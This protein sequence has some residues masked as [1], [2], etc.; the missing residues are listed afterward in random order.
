MI[1]SIAYSSHHSYTFLD[2]LPHGF[3]GSQL[4]SA[5]FTPILYS[6]VCIFTIC[7]SLAHILFI[8][9]N[10]RGTHGHMQPCSHWKSKSLSINQMWNYS[11][12][13]QVQ[14][15]PWEQVERGGVKVKIYVIFSCWLA[16]FIPVNCSFSHWVLVTLA[17]TR[18]SK[19]PSFVLHR[20][21][22]LAASSDWNTLFWLSS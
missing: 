8:F 7:F 1:F 4:F 21:T 6:G 18:S 10:R 9:L 14:K 20:V 22:T 11:R 19:A 2:F 13:W 17:L 3:Y 15:W 12:W 16:N 5:A